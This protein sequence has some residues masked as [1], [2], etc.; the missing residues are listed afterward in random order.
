MTKPVCL[1]HNQSQ[2]SPSQLLQ[3][4]GQEPHLQEP[5]HFV[6]LLHILQPPSSYHQHVR[7]QAAGSRP[8]GILGKYVV[9]LDEYRIIFGTC[10]GILGKYSVIF[11]NTVCVF[12]GENAVILRKIGLFLGKYCVISGH[13][14]GVFGNSMFFLSMGVPVFKSPREKN[15]ALSKFH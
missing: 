13:Y 7:Q 15:P 11:A 6:L 2:L 5:Q 14:N 3:C 8:G 9:I 12:F 10:N 1:H 4:A